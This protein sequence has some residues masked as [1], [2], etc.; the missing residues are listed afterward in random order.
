MIVRRLL[1]ATGLILALA[2]LGGCGDATVPTGTLHVTTT[3]TGDTL[4]PDGYTVMIAPADTIAATGHER[5]TVTVASSDTAAFAGLSEGAY[6]IALSG[7]QSNC[8]PED[9]Q[10][11]RASVS[12]EDTTVASFT[13]TCAPALL[14]HIVF[15]SEREGRAPNR[16]PEIYA[17][18]PDGRGLIRLTHNAEGWTTDRDWKPV[19][20]P[21]G[22]RIAFLSRRDN[23]REIYTA[24]PNGKSVTRLTHNV[25]GGPD[26]AWD[27][28]PTFAPEGSTMVY[29]S[30]RQRADGLGINTHLYAITPDGDEPKPLTSGRTAAQ[31]PAFSPDGKMIVYETYQSGNHDLSVIN[32]DGSAPRRLTRH[33]ASDQGPVWSP[34]GRQIVF[35]SERN[36][37]PDLYAVHPDGS[38]MTQLT[39]HEAAD[40]EPNYCPG[41]GPLVFVSRRAG[42]AELYA[43]SPDG[44]APTRL[45]NHEATDGSPACSPDGKR[46]AFT[47]DRD[48][49]AEIYTI[50]TDGTDLTRIT[51]HPATDE[52]PTWSPTR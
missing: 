18:R 4:D 31:N 28:N 17:I 29:D 6:H 16:N 42:N 1:V 8:Q 9:S 19:V 50:K 2:S 33:A 52:D 20:S 48:G 7:V 38:G 5:D 49:N 22:R 45:T 46:V 51:E 25:A 27:H 23:N 37:N 44:G 21:H 12:V 15:T 26:R 10:R 3:T 35:V 43:L 39:T 36:D 34:D 41:G 14:D 30:H 24:A 47:S 40:S 13:L 32:A 11:Q